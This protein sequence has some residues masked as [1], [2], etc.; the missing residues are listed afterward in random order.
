MTW[1]CQLQQ[2]FCDKKITNNG[3]CNKHRN[4]CGTTTLRTGKSKL[5]AN[6]IF[7]TYDKQLVLAPILSVEAFK[8]EEGKERVCTSLYEWALRILKPEQEFQLRG[9]YEYD[10]EAKKCWDRVIDNT[11]QATFGITDMD[12]YYG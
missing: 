4:Y 6:I 7:C 5:L 1:F 9:L 2:F 3:N 12:F 8:P 11:A 10:D